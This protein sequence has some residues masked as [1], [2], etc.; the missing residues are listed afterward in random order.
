[1]NN[2]LIL[3]LFICLPTDYYML[4]N[5]GP[6]LLHTYS[7]HPPKKKTKE[8]KRQQYQTNDENKHSKLVHNVYINAYIAGK[9]HI[10]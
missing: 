5:R 9:G 6:Q 1:M 4:H 10:R 8:E 3:L 7:A 2:M